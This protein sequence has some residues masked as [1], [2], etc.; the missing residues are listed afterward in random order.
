MRSIALLLLLV[1]SL[2]TCSAVHANEIQPPL[3]IREAVD[4]P[5]TVAAGTLWLVTELG[6]RDQFSTPFEPAPYEQIGRAD[7]TAVGLWNPSLDKASDALLIAAFAAPF[8]FNSLDNGIWSGERAHLGRWFWADVVVVLESVFIAGALTNMAKFAFTRYRP[9]TYIATDHPEAYDAIQQDEELRTSLQDASEEPD[10]A[11]SFWSGHTSLAFSAL[12]ASATLLTY[13]HL[14]GP[15]APLIALW[16]GTLGA[17][18]AMA[19]LRVRAGL[20]FPSDVLV[21]AVV[22]AAIG[23]VVPS[24][25]VHRKLRDVAITP[26]TVREGGGVA[27]YGRW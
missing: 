7:R 6:L 9:Y 5:I 3:E 2:L 26:L 14:D 8:L 27:L 1:P 15:P 21:G 12:C 16:G 24:L 11:L 19:V 23:I 10:S 13:K 20:H 22:G 25:H 18:V 4:L 17:G